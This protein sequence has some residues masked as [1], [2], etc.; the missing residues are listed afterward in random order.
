MPVRSLRVLESGL[1][2]VA[3]SPADDGVV[4]LIVCR[5]R[6][7]AREVLTEGTLDL[8]E[9]LVGDDWR[10]RGSGSRPDGSANPEAQVTLMNYRAALLFAGDP[11]RRSLAGDQFFVDLD[12]SEA[13]LPPGT[14]VQLGTAV[15]EISAKPHT[16]CAKFS[17]RFGADALRLVGSP[18]GRAMRLRGVNAKVV[19]PGTVRVGDVVRKVP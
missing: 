3:D 9:G 12:L 16:G 5:P 2:E 6:E 15:L 17:A 18:M 8:D 14:Q 19:S 1:A 13:N 4:S 10:A 11:E 7:D